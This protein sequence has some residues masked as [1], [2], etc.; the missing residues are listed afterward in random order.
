MYS[1]NSN[2]LFFILNF[3]TTLNPILYKPVNNVHI[4]LNS[5]RN[6]AFLHVDSLTVVSAIYGGIWFVCCGYIHICCI[7]AASVREYFDD[8]ECR[9]CTV[10]RAADTPPLNQT[11]SLYS[12]FSW[13]SPTKA[14]QDKIQNYYNTTAHWK[15]VLHWAQEQNR[16]QVCGYLNEPLRPI[17]ENKH[18]CCRCWGFT[19]FTEGIFVPVVVLENCPIIS[20]DLTVTA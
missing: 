8:F 11:R 17:A 13:R 5:E 15:A 12:E 10:K 19:V 20:A 16:L 1:C 4:R 18:H 14:F 9:H 7:D 6:V 3:F 2:Q